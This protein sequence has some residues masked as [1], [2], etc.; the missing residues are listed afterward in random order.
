MNKWAISIFDTCLIEG[1]ELE[2]IRL[3]EHGDMMDVVLTQTE[4]VVER[5]MKY[6][7]K[8]GVRNRVPFWYESF[9]HI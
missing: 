2:E 6:V 1:T 4:E 3:G 8:T 7:S 5:Y 9:D